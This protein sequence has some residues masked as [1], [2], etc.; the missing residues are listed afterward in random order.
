MY[1]YTHIY[2]YVYVYIYLGAVGGEALDLVRHDA[3]DGLAP[4]V[5]QALLD[6]RRDLA[7]LLPRLQEPDDNLV[8]R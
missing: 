6:E 1:I 8:E 3:V 4:E 5:V 2:M 7:V